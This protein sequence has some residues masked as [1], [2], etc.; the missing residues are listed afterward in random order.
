[1]SWWA[2]VAAVIA[3]LLLERLVR[4]FLA[5]AWVACSSASRRLWRHLARGSP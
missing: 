4:W 2:I 3:G 1:M 5:L